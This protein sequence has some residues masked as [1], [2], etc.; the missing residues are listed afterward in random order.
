M[1]FGVF[2]LGL[3]ESQIQQCSQLERSLYSQAGIG[4]WVVVVLSALAGGLN[5]YYINDSFFSVALGA[6]LFPV[7]LGFLYRILLISIKRPSGYFAWSKWKRWVPDI[8]TAVRFLIP[9]VMLFL[10]AMPIAA[11]L[12]F[13]EVERIAAEKRQE[14]RALANES[15]AVAGFASGYSTDLEAAQHTHYPVAVY[16]AL[17]QTGTT[18]TILLLV[19]GALFYPI[20]LL[21]LIKMQSRFTYQDAVNTQVET[22]ARG[23][24]SEWEQA[25]EQVIRKWGAEAAPH[26]LCYSDYPINA[27]KA[28][29]SKPYAA[30]DAAL[31][32]ALW[33]QKS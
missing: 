2:V 8:G 25:R 10:V 26:N 31:I 6:L 7:L 28:E 32:R 17:I 4:F 19:F 23:A 22:N 11:L 12:Q 14:L 5:L 20:A 29:I 15:T 24:F 21:Y 30:G 18:K 16:S 3:E 1:N 33:P 9:S 27:V 13:D